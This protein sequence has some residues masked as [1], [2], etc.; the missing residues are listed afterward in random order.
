MRHWSQ[1][2][3]MLCTLRQLRRVVLDDSSHADD[4]SDSDSD[5]ELSDVF[6]MD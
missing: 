6:G 2:P 3:Q 4:F 5:D 1:R